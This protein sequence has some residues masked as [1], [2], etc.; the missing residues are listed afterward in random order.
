MVLALH[1]SDAG[2]VPNIRQLYAK[3]MH[4]YASSQLPHETYGGCC[5]INGKGIWSI[6]MSGLKMS[7]CQLSQTGKIHTHV[8]VCVCGGGCHSWHRSVLKC[9][10][11]AAVYAPL[12]LWRMHQG[13]L[14]ALE[15]RAACLFAC[16]CETGLHQM[17]YLFVFISS[18]CVFVCHCFTYTK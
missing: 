16:L 5:Y 3:R 12:L 4:I 11:R 18:V 17:Q 6:R 10:Q 14:M 8:R 2:N 15:I 7:G 9:Y 1:A 13:C